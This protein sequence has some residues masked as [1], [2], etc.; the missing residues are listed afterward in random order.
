MNINGHFD[1]GDMNHSCISIDA[2]MDAMMDGVVMHDATVESGEPR[3]FPMPAPLDPRT[4]H[5]ELIF[6]FGTLESEH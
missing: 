2:M 4:I 6:I 1:N 5:C 3:D